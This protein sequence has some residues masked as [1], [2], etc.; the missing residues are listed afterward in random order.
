LKENIKKIENK[1]HIS[2]SKITNPKLE[3]NSLK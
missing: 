2:H 3:K 1:V